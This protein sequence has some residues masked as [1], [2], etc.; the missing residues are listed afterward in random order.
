[1]GDGSFQIEDGE[2]TGTWRLFVAVSVPEAVKD[3]IEM[4][5]KEMRA[6][7]GEFVR[8]TKRDQFH[9][10]LKFLGS[11]AQSRVPELTDVLHEACR[12]FN[13]MRLR[14]EGIGF[15][16]NLR[17]PRVAWVGVRDGQNV[18]PQLQARIESSLDPFSETRSGTVKLRRSDELF[19]G[20]V[21]LSRI[22]GAKKEIA[23]VWE[24]V[25]QRMNG[26]FFGEW[27]ADKVELIRSELSSNGSRYTTV[28][29]FPLGKL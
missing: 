16:P 25:A 21:T 23:E 13:A 3:E 1:M 12:P 22:R 7:P 18:L 8:W 6:L 29:E 14:A 5:R 9:L 4:V 15:F 20:H 2:G 28:A 10:T 19:V 17:C 26:R 11:V 27:T 24:R